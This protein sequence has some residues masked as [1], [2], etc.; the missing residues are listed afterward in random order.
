M[1]FILKRWEVEL[2]SYP[3]ME[4]YS[5]ILKPFEQQYEQMLVTPMYK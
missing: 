3:N 1:A 5:L 2:M 4:E